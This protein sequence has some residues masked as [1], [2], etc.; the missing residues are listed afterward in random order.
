M[1]IKNIL[2]VVSLLLCL[3][4]TSIASDNDSDETCYQEID[5]LLSYN[6]KITVTVSDGTEFFGALKKV[7]QDSIVIRFT[8]IK[9]VQSG[10]SQ[11]IL[12]TDISKIE[13]DGMREKNYFLTEGYTRVLSFGAGIL[14]STQVI[15]KNR[16]EEQGF[17]KAAFGIGFGLF[18]GE[19]LSRLTIKKFPV[20]LT[21][22]C[23]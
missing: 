8:P 1:S 4:A 10:V 3:T 2:V 12:I 5:S 22:Q 9:F 19:V 6:D 17:K 11:P 14:I 15:G 16:D 18:L 20:N 21:I 13:F 7:S 23:K